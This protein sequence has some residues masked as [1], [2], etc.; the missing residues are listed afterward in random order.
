MTVVMQKYYIEN[1]IHSRKFKQLSLAL[2]LKTETTVTS[3][4]N[5]QRYRNSAREQ[6]VQLFEADRNI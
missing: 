1:K 6:L 2:F 4:Q 3:A 5:H